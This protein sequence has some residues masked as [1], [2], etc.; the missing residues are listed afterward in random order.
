M[1]EE[2]QPGVE[3]ALPRSVE[4]RRRAG[5]VLA[6]LGRLPSRLLDGRLVRWA[7]AWPASPSG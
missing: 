1:M 6:G 4:P 5:A 2:N 7:P 3:G